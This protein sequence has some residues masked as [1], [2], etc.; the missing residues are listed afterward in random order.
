VVRLV[1]AYGGSGSGTLIDGNGNILTN[2]HVIEGFSSVK[3]YLGDRY[4]GAASVVG[5]HDLLDLAIVRINAGRSSLTPIPIS[6]LEPALGDEIITIGYPLNMSGE[7]TVTVGV[8]SASRNVEGQRYIQTDAAI[9]PGNSGGAALD[10]QGNFIGVPTWMYIAENIG[11]LIP[12]NDVVDRIEQLKRGVRTV[13]L[14]PTPTPR[15]T[16]TPTPT[17]IPRSTL[18]IDDGY[19]RAFV[20]RYSIP[21][22]TLT[23]SPAPGYDGMFPAGSRVHLFVQP[24]FPGS[25][26]LWQYVDW[27]D[28]GDAYVDL[29]GRHDI[30]IVIFPPAPTP[31]PTPTPTPIPH[32]TLTINDG[33]LSPFIDRYS[34]PNGTLTIGTAPGYDGKFP[35]GSRIQLWVTPDLTGSQIHW[36]YV[37]WSDGGS[38]YVDVVGNQ[39]IQIVIVPPAPTPTPTLSG[40]PSTYLQNGISFGVNG[41]HELAILE[42]DKAIQLYPDYA[43]AYSNR[44][45]SYRELGQ[46]ERAILDYDQAIRLSPNL[47]MAHNNRGDAFYQLGQFERAIENYDEAIRIDPYFAMAYSNRSFNYGLLGQYELSQADKATACS[48]D[49][50]YC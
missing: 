41:Y 15:P 8:V 45:W 20:D 38:A 40:N 35:A 42:F 21:N 31:T 43:E 2:Y 47:V 32:S 50:G 48:L 34:L 49:S 6:R 14:P 11:F 26:I 17:P 1:D 3:V 29:V 44:G 18:T 16:L 22:G 24:D 12:L 33:Y 36:Q 7:S 10:R 37:D 13:A 4:V 25:Q 27:Y 39:N 28:G 19:L 23:V 5:Y 9:N 30:Q 46:Y